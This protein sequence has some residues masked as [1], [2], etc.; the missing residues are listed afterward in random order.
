MDGHHLIFGE[1][2]D[3]L[4]GNV[5][6]DTHDER[7]RQKIARLLVDTLGYEKGDIIPRRELTI[8]ADDKKAKVFVDFVIRCG[9]K[10]GMLIKYGPGSL[11]TRHQPVRAMARLINGYQ[12]PVVVV[13][14]G[15]D[16]ETLD[17][18]SEK[19]IARGIN[20]IPNKVQLAKIVSEHG[21]LP[22]SEK[23]REMAARIVYCYEIDGACPCDT[24]VCRL[25][26]SR[27]V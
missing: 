22:V 13:V 5:M 18:V 23:K 21:F 1:L 12:V 9:E 10:I 16:A 24:T 6:P 15:E 25:E 3:F 11:T 14:N 4:T 27:T 2:V 17:T 7:Y 26:N 19:V 20:C 8:S